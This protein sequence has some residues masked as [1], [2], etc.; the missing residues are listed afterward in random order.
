MVDTRQI[1]EEYRLSHWAQVMQERIQS[2]LSITAFCKQI[3]IGG[4][5]YF[6]WQRKLRTAA[7]EMAMN[8]PEDSAAGFAEVQVLEAP[9]QAE[10]V[11]CE[12]AG[13]LNVEIA[14]MRI[15]AD[16]SYPPDKLAALI[17]EL[18]QS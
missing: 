9:V 6:Y 2:G 17:R 11:E 15:T 5:T 10:P 1:A 7:C 3:G 12:Q 13:Q 8:R 18:M 4:N 16:N 14:G